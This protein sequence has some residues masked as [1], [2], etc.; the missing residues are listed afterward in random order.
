MHKN[1]AAACKLREEFLEE[2]KKKEHAKLI[3]TENLLAE[4]NTELRKLQTELLDAKNLTISALEDDKNAGINLMKEMLQEVDA[5]N[6]QISAMKDAIKALDDSGEDFKHNEVDHKQVFFFLLSLSL[7][8][9]ST[10]S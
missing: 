1:L 5:K 9:L 4:A 3:H 10:Y 7:S 8:L 6:L 2:G